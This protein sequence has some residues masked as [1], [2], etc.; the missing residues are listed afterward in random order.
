MKKIML[1]ALFLLSAFAVY[2]SHYMGG[3]ITWECT[4][5]GKYIFTLKAYR[6]CAGI[7]YA[8]TQTINSN[9]SAGNFTVTL[10]S[11][12]PKDISPVVCA[13]EI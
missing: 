2:P 3:E 11:G 8:N 12:Y 13:A 7:L 6:E 5:N 1:I 9:S 10:Q 4:N